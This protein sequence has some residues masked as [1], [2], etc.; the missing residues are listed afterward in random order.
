MINT[1]LNLIILIGIIVNY[2]YTKRLED[3]LNALK[4]W[5]EV[6]RKIDFEA[7]ADCVEKEREDNE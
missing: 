5:I 3:R 6:F 2:A 7:M 1:I 4:S